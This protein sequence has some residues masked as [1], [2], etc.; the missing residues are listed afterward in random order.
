MSDRKRI[1][2]GENKNN[3]SVYY[4]YN[5]ANGKYYIGITKQEPEKRWNNGYGYHNQAFGAAIRKYGWNNFEHVVVETG[6]SKEM[7][8]SLEKRLIQECDSFKKGYNC[9]M[10]GESAD[11]YEMPQEVKEKIRKANSGK[12]AYWYGKKMP[13]D[14]VRK[15][16]EKHINHPSCSK[17]VNQYDLDGNYVATYP[18]LN[19]VT[20]QFGVGVAKALHGEIHVFHGFQWRFTDDC[21]EQKPIA[22]FFKNSKRFKPVAQY[23]LEGEKIAEYY[24]VRE[25]KEKG[26]ASQNVNA[27]CH[28]R[29]MTYKNFFW[30]YLREED[31]VG[32][33]ELYYDFSRMINIIN[34]DSHASDKPLGQYDLQ[35]NL[36]NHFDSVTKAAKAV[37]G[38]PNNISIVCN[39]RKK[40]SYGS[41]WCFDDDVDSLPRK[42]EFA[43][44]PLRKCKI[45]RY[46]LD[47]EYIDTFN[48]AKPAVK[49]L[50]F[51]K[52][53]VIDACC[54]GMIPDAFGYIWKYAE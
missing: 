34:S 14:V 24:T 49:Q 20:R 25:L 23:N 51:G 1:N 32:D 21:D 10:G 12:N 5:L 47:D 41:I 28:L 16:A 43:N 15:V 30:R 27:V 6:L 37:G 11:G 22:K 45:S 29:R 36:I 42:I 48:G 8:V 18:S 52:A 3:Y 46:T 53:C 31:V 7:A 19:E 33:N 38:A 40:S 13:E 50:G 17:E 39:S 9:S 4:H 35:G 44:K 26:F 54:F 2:M